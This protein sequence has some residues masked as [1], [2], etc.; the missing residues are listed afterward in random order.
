MPRGFAS[1]DAGTRTTLVAAIVFIY[2]VALQLARLFLRPLELFHDATHVSFTDALAFMGSTLLFQGGFALFA[3]GVTGFWQTRPVRKLAAWSV[4]ALAVLI[5]VLETAGHAYFLN[6]GSTLDYPLVAFSAG[7][8]REVAVLAVHSLSPLLLGSMISAAAAVAVLPWI[9]DRPWARGAAASPPPT[10]PRWRRALFATSMIASLPL[11][12]A[13]LLTHTSQAIDRA[14]IRDPV[15]NVIA[16]F[17]PSRRAPHSAQS[18]LDDEPVTIGPISAPGALRNVVIVILESA[19]AESLTPWNASLQDAPF[20]AEL[21]KSSVRFDRFYTVQTHT[22][23][24]LRAI[25]C[26][27][28][29][30]HRIRPPKFTHGIATHCLP[31]LL[32]DHGFS[33]VYFQTADERVEHRTFVIFS[34][35]YHD[36]IGP[37]SFGHE[38]F[39]QANYLGYEDDSMLAPTRRWLEAQERSKPFLATYLTVNA[40]YRC[41]LL[42]RHGPQR[43]SDSHGHPGT[44][45]SARRSVHAARHRAHGA[46]APRF[47][48]EVG[49]L[50]G[51]FPHGPSSAG[52]D[53]RGLLRSR[54]VPQL[55]AGRREIHP[56]LRTAS[57]RAVRPWPRPEGD[58]ES[59]RYFSPACS[60]AEARPARLGS[61]DQRRICGS[62]S[63]DSASAPRF[64][65]S[66]IGL[67]RESALLEQIAR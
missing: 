56:S 28:E 10:Q 51:Q 32:R 47:R 6:T 9:A 27:F 58:D 59:R 15:L 17:H 16:T 21:A 38:G 24:A 55:G 1:T 62:R 57:G 37:S 52:A 40:H 54:D 36:F 49:A 34:M 23:R 60:R 22:G 64:R 25:L 8:M 14:T 39:E 29:P 12:A 2:G 41:A 31:N 20:L 65:R 18:T 5:A 48:R 42:T 63:M 13:G 4:Q 11:A 43:Y 50:P 35:G 7:R 26:G 61:P 33:T 45:R 67:H 44:A 66:G 53:P 30:Q 46:R 3:F 19:R